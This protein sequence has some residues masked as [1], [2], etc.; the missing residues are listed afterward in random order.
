MHCFCQDEGGM[1][2]WINEIVLIRQ[3]GYL[4]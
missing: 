4:T 1:A 3:L 2:L